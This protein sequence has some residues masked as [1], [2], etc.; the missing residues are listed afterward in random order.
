VAYL[1][2]AAVPLLG[3]ELWTLAGWI[4]DGPAQ[5]TEFRD[6][7]S[8]SWYAAR[9]LEGLVVASVA[10][11]VWH[12][13]RERRRLGRLGTDALLIVGMFTAAFWD[14]VYN[15]LTPA[16]LYSSNWLN[17]NDWFAHAPLIVNPDAGDMPWPVIVVGVGYP[18]WGVGFAAL[19]NR[20]MAAVRRRRPEI[21]AGG[22]VATAFLV[23]GVLTVASFSVF[24][25]FDL[26]NAP[27][28]RLDFLGDS[29]LAFFFYSGGI[30]F[31]GLACV[32]FFRDSDGRTL[33]ERSGSGA[34]R[35]LA[36]IATCQLIVVIGWGLLTVPFSLHSSPYPELPEHLING[37]CDSPGVTGTR[38][39]P[40]P[41]SPGFELPIAE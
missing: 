7:G 19:V 4:G 33:V 26:M 2:L 18:L 34:V 8:T 20:A 41:G 17:V 32:R 22:L 31:G 12:A 39:G 24:R 6:H 25:A 28:Y 14:P 3:Y 21:A 9:V 40:C 29:Q 37:L 16:W 35:V 1:A 13:V 30:V 11:F 38:Y 36:A 10:A 15:W 5:V 23:A 27:G